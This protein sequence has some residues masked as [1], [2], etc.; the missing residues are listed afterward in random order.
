MNI[1]SIWKKMEA[2][3]NFTGCLLIKI[4]VSVKGKK[5]WKPT[6]D[7]ILPEGSNIKDGQSDMEPWPIPNRIE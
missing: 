4:L 3:P 1:N 2:K 6:L 5:V 7:C